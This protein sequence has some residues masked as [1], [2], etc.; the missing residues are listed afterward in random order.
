M[1]TT[2]DPPSFQFTKRLKAVSGVT[3]SAT[4]KATF[5]IGAKRRMEIPSLNAVTPQ[6]E[7]RVSRALVAATWLKKDKFAL[8]AR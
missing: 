3:A 1:P 8:T 5:R 7:K 2:L 4:A 6:A